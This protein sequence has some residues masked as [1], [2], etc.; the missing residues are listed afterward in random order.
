MLYL[1]KHAADDWRLHKADGAEIGSGWSSDPR[2]D[3][4]QQSVRPAF[5]DQVA[6]EHRGA[7]LIGDANARHDYARA[8]ESWSFRDLTLDGETVPW[9]I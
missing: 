4:P 6:D 1:V 2:P 9:D 8:T 7:G 3:D 5:V